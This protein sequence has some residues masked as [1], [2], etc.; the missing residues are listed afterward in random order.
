MPLE[1]EELSDTSMHVAIVPQLLGFHPEDSLVVMAYRGQDPLVTIRMDLPEIGDTGNW[2]LPLQSWVQKQLKRESLHAILLAFH[3]AE[4]AAAAHTAIDE[5]SALLTAYNV[6]MSSSLLVAGDQWAQV[7]P[8]ALE[9]GLPAQGVVS[10]ATRLAAQDKLPGVVHPSRNAALDTIGRDPDTCQELNQALDPFRTP[11]APDQFLNLGARYAQTLSGSGPL[12]FAI[13]C[14]LLQ[15]LAFYRVRDKVIVDL[16]RQLPTSLDLSS[17]SLWW[18]VRAAPD[19]YLA[20]IASVAAAVA[21]SRGDGVIVG[22]LLDRVFSV[23][24]SYTLA[25]LL[26]ALYCS[27][28]DPSAWTDGILSLSD[29][30][31]CGPGTTE[32]E[33]RP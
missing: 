11:P 33:K 9:R 17:G 12:G 29:Q 31:L 10:P 15:D 16:V 7:S 3:E 27:G 20:P 8:E 24:P 2:L 14:E 21:Y 32:E 25:E 26:N 23:D 18:L 28:T 22:G 1:M 5:V 30:D 13:A 19:Q 6:P 4:K